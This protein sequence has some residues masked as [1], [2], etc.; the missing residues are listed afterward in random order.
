[1]QLDGG[2]H[3]AEGGGCVLATLNAIAIR[4]GGHGGTPLSPGFTQTPGLP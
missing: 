2:K 1:M 4:W 3:D